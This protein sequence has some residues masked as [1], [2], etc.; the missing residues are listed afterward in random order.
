MKSF[1]SN[2]NPWT[3]VASV[4]QQVFFSCP[5][6]SEHAKLPAFVLLCHNLA[7]THSHSQHEVGALGFYQGIHWC[8]INLVELIH[9]VSKTLPRAG[10]E[11]S[12]GKGKVDRGSALLIR[13][14]RI[15]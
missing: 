9:A 4:F 8:R 12:T 10:P 6:L 1:K 15:L 13:D 7:A 5:K 11:L 2:Y 14:Y 3:L